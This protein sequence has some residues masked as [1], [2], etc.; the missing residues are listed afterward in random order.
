MLPRLEHHVGIVDGVSKEKCGWINDLLGGTRQGSI[1]S[2]VA[3][4][5]ISCVIFRTLEK[6]S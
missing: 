6:R 5:D 2:G 4:I 3:C 1:F